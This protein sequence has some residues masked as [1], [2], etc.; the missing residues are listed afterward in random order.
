MAVV[1]LAAASAQASEAA[2]TSGLYGRVLI[3]PAMP[4]CKI[5]TPCSR[6]AKDF[7]LAFFRNGHLIGTATTD[8]RGRY[9]I[10]LP[11]GRYAVRPQSRS[12]LRQGLEPKSAK[13]PR[14]RFARHD[15]TLDIGIR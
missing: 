12:A 7:K 4:V 8:E 14:R 5:G 15:L 10:A 11:A 2:R 1:S 3:D 9:R 13:V 6:P